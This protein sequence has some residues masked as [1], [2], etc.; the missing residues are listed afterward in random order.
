MDNH[1]LQE[2]I[3]RTDEWLSTH[4]ELS[5][6]RP[7]FTYYAALDILYSDYHTH[8]VQRRYQP[9]AK[10]ELAQHTLGVMPGTRLSERLTID[11]VYN[12]GHWVNAQR[13]A[14]VLDG[15]RYYRDKIGGQLVFGI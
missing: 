13:M 5:P 14:W 11:R 9:M 7:D 4:L 2:S 1:T 8:M 3:D 6:S 15:V 12:R 10:Y